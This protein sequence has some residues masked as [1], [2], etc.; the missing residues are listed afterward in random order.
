MI[1]VITI[2]TSII[3]EIIVTKYD[4]IILIILNAA[5]ACLLRQM[6]E[7]QL[8]P[9]TPQSPFKR[10]LEHFKGTLKAAKANSPFHRRSHSNG[11]NA[12]KPEGG[13]DKPAEAGGAVQ[14][15]ATAG[16]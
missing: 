5:H 7:L 6:G 3:I 10:A 4:L 8:A 9:D 2:I 12:F 13:S 1:V 14:M 16:P 11:R 15:T